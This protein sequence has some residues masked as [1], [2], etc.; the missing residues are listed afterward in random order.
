MD[1]SW[2]GQIDQLREKE[3]LD[4]RYAKPR[5]GM[6]ARISE[7]RETT[8]HVEEKGDEN[9]F[10]RVISRICARQINFFAGGSLL[11]F[12]NWILNLF[13]SE[14]D[15]NTLKRNSFRGTVVSFDERG[16]DVKE[17]SAGRTNVYIY[18]YI[19]T[20]IYMYVCIYSSWHGGLIGR[21]RNGVNERQ[22]VDGGNALVSRQW[23]SIITG[24]AASINIVRS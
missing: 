10:G 23:D 24:Q 8:F 3:K 5:Y 19:Y 17:R 14:T 18:I 12:L 21:E 11:L 2:F 4:N 9:L 16:A 20:Y 6:D 7:P 1:P 22:S 15:G 13:D